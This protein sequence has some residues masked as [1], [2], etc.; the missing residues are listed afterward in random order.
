[1]DERLKERYLGEVYFLRAYYYFRLVRAFGD[2]P[3]PMVPLTSSNEWRQPRSPKSVIY[4]QILS[5]LKNAEA[6]LW[7]KSES[8]PPRRP[9]SP[10]KAPHRPC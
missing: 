8:P 6:M 1:M 4:G 5:D 2:V 3:M 10:P 7:K 9:A